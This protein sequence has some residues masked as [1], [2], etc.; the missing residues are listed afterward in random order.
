MSRAY[1]N[2]K[3]KYNKDR[4]NLLY[5]TQCHIVCLNIYPEICLVMQVQVGITETVMVHHLIGAG[6]IGCN[7][8]NFL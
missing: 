7:M 4:I 5:Q 3:Q 2:R 6:V 8:G 1:S